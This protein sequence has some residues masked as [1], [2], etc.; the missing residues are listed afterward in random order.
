MIPVKLSEP[1]LLE[2]VLTDGNESMYPRAFIYAAGGSTPLATADLVHKA[3]GRYYAEWTPTATGMFSAVFLTYSDAARTIVSIVYGRALEQI[4]VSQNALDD[5]AATLARVLGLVHENAFIDNMVY[6][7]GVLV[8]ARV[9]V[10]N[11]GATCAAATDG[12]SETAG[13]VATY[14]IEATTEQG[15]TDLKTYRMVRQ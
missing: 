6:A 11:S 13:L 1:A 14:A 10:F 9:R 5:L 12:G 3:Q 15:G 8:T 7:N 2:L 4:Q